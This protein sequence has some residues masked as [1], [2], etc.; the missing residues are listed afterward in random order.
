MCIKYICIQIHYDGN[1]AMCAS[2]A[3]QRKTFGVF[4]DVF[5]LLISIDESLNNKCIIQS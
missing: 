4:L 3:T 5:F 2:N 1:I